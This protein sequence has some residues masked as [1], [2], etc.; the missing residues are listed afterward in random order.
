MIATLNEKLPVHT[1]NHAP[2]EGATKNMKDSFHNNLKF[3]K[4]KSYEE[5]KV[6]ENSNVQFGRKR[7][8]NVL[9]EF[10]T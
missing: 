4:G 3:T 5:I 1:Q 9:G 2:T 6:T 10:S 7:G 8:N